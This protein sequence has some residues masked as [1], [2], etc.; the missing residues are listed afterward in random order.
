MIKREKGKISDSIKIEGFITIY[1]E[2]EKGNRTYL[3]NNTKNHFVNGGLKGLL[4]AL[5]GSAFQWSAYGDSRAWT[6]DWKM[7]LGTDT[8]TPTTTG[9]TALVSPIGAAPGTAPSSLWGTDRA[10]PSP[11]VWNFK[12][13]ASWGAGTISGTVGEIGLYF[14]PFDVIT[15]QWSE[16]NVTKSRVMI[17]R[18][19]S[20]DGDFTPVAIDP[21][22][23][24]TVEWE[25]RISY[26]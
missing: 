20:A 8:T 23:S 14:R 11:G 17:S 1:Q 16:T 7:Y 6:Y 9:M 4:S 21:L 10:N 19:S 22:K 12:A 26:E 2:D 13:S 18:L 3:V 24:F 15:Y 25:V 5:L